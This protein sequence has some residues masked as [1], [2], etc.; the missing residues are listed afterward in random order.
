ME[1]KKE[2]EKR[3]DKEE[4]EKNI[5]KEEK[6]KGVSKSKESET[7]K[8][9]LIGI[10]VFILIIL[11]VVWGANAMNSFNYNG[12][13]FV[14]ESFCDAEPCL[15]VYKASFPVQYKDSITGKVVSTDYNIYLRNDPRKLEEV[16]FN[17]ELLL[18]KDVVLDIAGNFDC[19]GDQNIAIANMLKL[20]IFGVKIIKDENATCDSH[21][22]YTFIQ[23]Q[24]ANE[25]Y[26]EQTGPSCYT[27]NVAD[28]EILEVTERFMVEYFVKSE[29]KTREEGKIKEIINNLFN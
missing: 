12:V 23:V 22:R 21:G 11:G 15:L 17:G 8:K 27:L 3:E 24:E 9:F 29:G 13:D 28:C 7:L 25:S 26:I 1:D 2:D 6:E 19:D 20:D 4:K 16:P 10:G 5:D 18:R 14:K